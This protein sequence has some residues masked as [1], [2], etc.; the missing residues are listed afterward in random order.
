M[1]NVGPG[2]NFRVCL[3]QTYTFGVLPWLVQLALQ[4]VNKATSFITFQ[5]PTT[6]AEMRVV[7]CCVVLVACSLRVLD[8]SPFCSKKVAWDALNNLIQIQLIWEFL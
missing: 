3:V 7:L 1:Y 2:R 8:V 5:K 4:G 6:G